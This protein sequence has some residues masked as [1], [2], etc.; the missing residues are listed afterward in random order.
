MS[1]TLT[2]FKKSSAASICWI[3]I[4]TIEYM[5]HPMSTG[6][7]LHYMQALIIKTLEMIS[8]RRILCVWNFHLPN[9]FAASLFPIATGIPL[10]SP[11]KQVY[12]ENVFSHYQ[13]LCE[14][15]SLQRI[16][17]VFL[18]Q[19]WIRLVWL[20]TVCFIASSLHVTHIGF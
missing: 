10:I 9:L 17:R 7:A 3:Y 2:S 13:E 8:K 20:S 12:T 18:D 15:K 1:S 6:Y 16:A 11:D 5:F 19:T 14:I 4:G